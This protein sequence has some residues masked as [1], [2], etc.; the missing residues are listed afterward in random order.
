[1]GI[2]IEATYENGNLKLA[3][4][5]PLKEHERV[6]VTIESESS[7]AERTAGMLQWCGDPEL[8][9]RI[10]EDEEFGILESR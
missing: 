2:T 7:W 1:M 10:A 4:P 6:R 5:L 3:K 9:R 8:L